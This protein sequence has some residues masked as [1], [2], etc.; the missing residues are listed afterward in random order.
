MR[1][2]DSLQSYLLSRNR[3]T[4]VPQK[5]SHKSVIDYVGNAPCHRQSVSKAKVAPLL[6]SQVDLFDNDEEEFQTANIKSFV[7]SPYQDNDVSEVPESKVNS[8]HPAPTNEKQA[9]GNDLAAASVEN[10]QTLQTSSTNSSQ[11]VV[12]QVHHQDDVVAMASQL[13]IE[14]LQTFQWQ[15]INKL[16]EGCWSYLEASVALVRVYVSLSLQ[17]Y[18]SIRSLHLTWNHLSF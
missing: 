16:L 12:H 11:N 9:S 6:G 15:T 13:N 18:S 7:S 1:F 2:F 17:Y 4:Y 14:Q 8:S 3:I 10:V 5:L